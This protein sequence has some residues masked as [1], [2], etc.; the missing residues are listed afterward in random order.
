MSLY[1]HA[2]RELDI[3]Y[4]KK[5]LKEEVNK[6]MYNNILSLIKL[7]AKQEHSGAS[8]A[9]C[10][11]F[12][13]TLAKFISLGE[14]TSNPKEWME[15]EPKMYQSRRNPSCFSTD[16]EYYYDLDGEYV[17]KWKRL[18]VKNLTGL[19]LIKLK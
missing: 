18:F 13:H 11:E 9:Y 2:K 6:T 8:A 15:V 10:L 5:S 1:K 7:F 14:L 3:I 4:D 19:K 16:L 12:F 17:P